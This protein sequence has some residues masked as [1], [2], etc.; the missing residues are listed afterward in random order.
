MALQAEKLGGGKDMI[1]PKNPPELFSGFTKTAPTVKK[2]VVAKTVT[3]KSET[4]KEAPKKKATTAMSFGAKFKKERKAG[5]STFMWNGKS[6]STATKD[7]VKAS[8]SKNLR[9]HLNKQN[10]KSK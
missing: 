3:P 2:K 7:D 9:E 5:K 8:G 6:Y 10:K 1:D 4:K